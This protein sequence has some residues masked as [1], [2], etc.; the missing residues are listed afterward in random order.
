MPIRHDRQSG[1]KARVVGQAVGQVVGQGPAISCGL[2][3]KIGWNLSAITF[4][5]PTLDETRGLVVKPR[6]IFETEGLSRRRTG[7]KFRQGSAMTPR[8]R[9][10]TNQCPNL[11][12]F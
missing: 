3:P 1:Q 10:A 6:W 5:K 7:L 4:L 8:H 11:P 12:Q 9:E 2:L